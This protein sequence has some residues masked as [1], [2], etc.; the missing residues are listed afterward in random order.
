MQGLPAQVGHAPGPATGLTRPA[1]SDRSGREEMYVIAADGVGEPQ[2]ITEFDTLKFSFAWSPNSKEIAFTG[3]DNKLR[4]YVIDTKQTTE[5]SSSKYGNI[6]APARLDFTVIG[7]AV[8]LA[9]RLE[10][11]AAKLGHN[12]VLSSEFATRCGAEVVSANKH[13]LKGLSEPQEVFVLIEPP[14]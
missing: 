1:V 3:S 5:L 12:L 10:G 13:P 11:V 7:P 14:N 2:K 4:K 9:A 6:G 8:N